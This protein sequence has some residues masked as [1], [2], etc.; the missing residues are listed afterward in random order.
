[1]NQLFTLS[2][3]LFLSLSPRLA[4][5]GGVT[6]YTSLRVFGDG[7]CTTTQG[8]GGSNFYGNRY[9]NGR[10]WVEVL[11]EWQGLTYDAGHNLSYFGQD[12]DELLANLASHTVPADVAT[13][14]YVVWTGNADFVEF[15]FA[16]PPGY[17]AADIPAW[18]SFIN[19]SIAD[20]EDAIEDLHAKGVRH[21]VLPSAADIAAAPFFA[22]DPA[23]AAFIRARIDDFNAALASMVAGLQPGVPGMTIHLVD[24]ASFFDDVLANPATYGVHSPDTYALLEVPLP[25]DLAGPGADYV[26]WDDLHP[27]AKVQIHIAD[28]VQQVISPPGVQSISSVPGGCQLSLFHVP[29]GRDGVIDGSSDLSSWVEDLNFA[30]TTTSQLVVVPSSEPRRFFRARYPVVWSWP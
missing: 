20:H 10:V 8:P 12:S 28:R 7:V 4:A 24:I 22:M 2:L 16:N 29:V 30:S 9:C 21:L 26:F 19:D 15:T 25:P 3:A 17:S 13:A 27:S 6:A 5:I 11:A 14:L 23:D 1:M 18:T